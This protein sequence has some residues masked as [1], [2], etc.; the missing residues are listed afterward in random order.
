MREIA[1]NVLSIFDDASA[2]GPE[3]LSRG[4]LLDL[5]TTRMRATLRRAYPSPTRLRAA[6]QG[7]V[8]LLEPSPV[9]AR[10]HGSAVSPAGPGEK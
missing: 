4:I 9:S 5:D 6:N 3:K 2:P 1:P 10:G 7:L 8:R